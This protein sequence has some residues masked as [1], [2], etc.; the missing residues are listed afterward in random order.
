MHLMSLGSV[1]AEGRVRAITS[2]E[3]GVRSTTCPHLRRNS[4][5]GEQQPGPERRRA[6][7]RVI[8]R[9]LAEKASSHVVV[10]RSTMFRQHRGARDPAP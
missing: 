10:V 9:A 5:Q 6:S 7:C 8:G 4:Q 3:E 2:V 1:V